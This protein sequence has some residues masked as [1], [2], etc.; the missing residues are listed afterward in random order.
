MRVMTV[1]VP[2]DDPELPG[3]VRVEIAPSI[4]VTPNGVYVGINGHFQLSQ[5]GQ[6]ANAALAADVLMKQ[7]DETRVLEGKLI[8]ALLE[9]I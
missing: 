1:E 6:R 7:W 2:R 3:F 4:R 9:A 5:G 8:A